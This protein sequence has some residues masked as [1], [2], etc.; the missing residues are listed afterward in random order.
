MITNQLAFS[1]LIG[2]G[3]FLSACGGERSSAGHLE[4]YSKAQMMMSTG[5]SFVVYNAKTL[6]ERRLGL[7]RIQDKD[8]DASRGM[9]FIYQESASRQLWMPETYFDI[10]AFFLN[11]EFQ[12]IDAQRALK[13]FPYKADEGNVPR[14]KKVLAR[15]ILE[16][17]SESVL[18]EKLKLGMK[19]KL[20]KE[21]VKPAG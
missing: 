7:S 11:E 8:F 10:D 6:E 5:E 21:Q 13:H 19:L 14:S 2:V 3:V 18:A 12:I 4:D 9:L 1:L 16:L 17:K 15:Y 20:R